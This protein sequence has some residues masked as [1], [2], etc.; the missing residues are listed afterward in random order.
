MSFITDQ[1]YLGSQEDAFSS[2]FMSQEPTAVLN[3]AANVPMTP[4][5]VVEYLHLPMYDNGTQ[6]LLS[7]IPPAIDFINRNRK[8]GVRV[9]V[10][11]LAGISRSASI[12][13]AY[14]MQT[15]RLRFSEAQAVVKK[16]RSVT[17]PGMWF[18]Y[19]LFAYESVLN[20]PNPE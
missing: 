2:E 6:D 19:K 3:V 7:F 1:L 10:H 9:L 20:P 8:R 5:A 11:C 16:Q 15:Q 14:L 13:I 4:H 18:V 12:V 17:D